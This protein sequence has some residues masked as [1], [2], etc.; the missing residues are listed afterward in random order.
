MIV[1][2]IIIATT[3]TFRIVHYLL[4][5][6]VTDRQVNRQEG[7]KVQYIPILSGATIF[8]LVDLSE[9]FAKHVET[10]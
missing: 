6:Q 5:C 10:K 9:K 1:I 3:E 8:I 2:I 7:E 4:G